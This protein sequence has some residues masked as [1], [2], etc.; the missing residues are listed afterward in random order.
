MGQWKLVMLRYCPALVLILAS[1][2]IGC[3]GSIAPQSTTPSGGNG[4]TV[5]GTLSVSGPTI[6]FGNVNVGSS[7][8]QTATLA[9]A[10]SAVTISSGSWSGDGFSVSGITFPVTLAAGQNAS[11]T[12]R[13][14][15]QASG[16]ASGAISFI[17][18]AANSPTTAA[19]AGTGVQTGNVA[20]KV[21]LFWDAS[22]SQVIGYNVYRGT[23]SGGPYPLKLTPSPQPGTSLIDNSVAAGTIYYYVATSVDQSSV[24]SIYS[25]QIT[26][27]IP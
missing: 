25:N 19:L 18:N 15:P 27:T 9:A 26:M 21:S 7:T 10:T 5:P 12:V 13:F 8:N 11:F 22:L 3:G 1:L 14:A 2:L 20:H 6:S 24:E 4:N 23:T 17:S 16:A